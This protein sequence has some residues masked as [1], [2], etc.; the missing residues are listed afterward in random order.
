[1]HQSKPLLFALTLIIYGTAL[2]GCGGSDSGSNREATETQPTA[3]TQNVSR[4]KNSS[5]LANDERKVITTGITTEAAFAQLPHLGLLL[6]LQQPPNDDSHWYGATQDGLIHRFENHPE[7]NQYTT[8]LDIRDRLYYQQGSELGLLGMAFH[9]QFATNGEIF[10]S[11]TANAPLRS[12]ISRFTA[13]GSG[14]REEILLEVAQPYSNHNG[15]NIAFGP[16]GYLYI[17]LGDGGDGGDPHGHGQNSASLLGSMLRIDVNRGAPYAIPSDNPFASNPLC[18]NRNSTTFAQ[19]CPEIF[20]WG[21]RNPWRWSFDR[22]TGDRWAGAGGQNA[23]EEIDIIVRGGNY[24]WNSMEGSSCYNRN[25]CSQ[26]GL[27]L[28]VASYGHENNDRSVVGGYRYRGENPDLQTLLAG[29]YLYGDTYSGRI[30]GLREENGIYRSEELLNPSLQLLYSFAED[31]KGELYLLDPA[32]GSSA[33][34]INIYKI[35]AATA[36]A[37]GTQPPQKL[38]QSGCVNAQNP[39]QAVDAM[40]AYEIISPLWSDGAEKRRYFALPDASTLEVTAAGD[41]TFPPGSVLM[42]EFLIGDKLGETRLLYHFAS[43]W[44]GYSYAWQYDEEG[45]PLDAELQTTTLTTTIGGQRWYYPSPGECME[46]HTEPSGIVLGPELAQL[47]LPTATAPAVNQ[48]TQLEMQGLFSAPLSESQKNQRLYAYDDLTATPEARAKSYL[49][50][51]CAHC[52]QP[53]GVNT[54]SMDLRYQT[55]LPAMA[56]CDVAPSRGEMAIENPRLL[57]PATTADAAHSVITA[58]MLA[59]DKGLQMPPLAREIVD[60]QAVA[61]LQ[62]WQL[63]LLSCD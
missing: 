18:N 12:V 19:S 39:Q 28:P 4:P 14:W 56:I 36:A 6:S 5:C 61:L 16:D 52:H 23:I 63:D 54:T 30:W 51:N 17:G 11:Y 21:L 35:V 46:C 47:N 38:S 37:G 43:G 7:V 10:L 41:L 31:Q 27:T 9:P 34:G 24:G 55:P 26:A 20:A 22:A 40:V 45:K 50:S 57:A 49:H 33:K 13:A 59:T 32:F 42:K 53:G 48:L 25:S 60:E 15:G 1:M 3:T 58:R 44:K 62:Q 29:V 2:T 8:Y